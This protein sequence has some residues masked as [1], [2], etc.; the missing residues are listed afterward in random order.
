MTVEF[1][2]PVS[3]SRIEIR[4]QGGFAAQECTLLASLGGEELQERAVFNPQD[5]NSLQ[6]KACLHA[7]ACAH[8]RTCSVH[9]WSIH[10]LHCT[11]TCSAYTCHVKLT[12]RA[13]RSTAPSIVSQ[14]DLKG[15]VDDPL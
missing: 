3:I 13:V 11:C 7:Y 12:R 15:M 9:E 8:M 2:H 6:V 14:L 4:F 5:T 1:P 10:T